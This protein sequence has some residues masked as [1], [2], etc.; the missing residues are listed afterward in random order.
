MKQRSIISHG[1]HIVGDTYGLIVIDDSYV[2]GGELSKWFRTGGAVMSFGVCEVG[3]WKPR[4][5][6]VSTN[7]EA[8]L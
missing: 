8:R 2:K 4:W 6:S 5:S 1:I 3:N 7:A